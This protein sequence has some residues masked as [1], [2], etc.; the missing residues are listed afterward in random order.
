MDKNLKS[1]EINKQSLFCNR[2][3]TTELAVIKRIIRKYYVQPYIDKVGILGPWCI[4][5]NYD[6]REG[7]V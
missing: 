1:E 7:H 6:N 3:I 4:C 5:L 2:D